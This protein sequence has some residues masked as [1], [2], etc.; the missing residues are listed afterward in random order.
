MEDFKNLLVGAPFVIGFV[1]LIIYGFVN[2]NV[3]LYAVISTVILLG[4]F[5]CLS[6]AENIGSDIRKL[7]KSKDKMK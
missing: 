3:F 5:I 2:A 4:V 1:L 7:L 6:I